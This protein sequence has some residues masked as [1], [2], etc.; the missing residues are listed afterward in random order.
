MNFIGLARVPTTAVIT[1]AANVVPLMGVVFWGW[2]LFPIIFLYWLE[3]AVIGVYNIAKLTRKNPAKSTFL[4]PIFLFHYGFFMFGHLALVYKLFAPDDLYGSLLP[5]RELLFAQ[6]LGVWPALITLGISHGTSFVKN[7]LGKHEYKDVDLEELMGAPYRRILLMQTVV[8][9]GGW[10]ITIFHAPI[11][12][13]A[14]LIVL[15]TIADVRA[16][17]QEHA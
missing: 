2:E 7:F 17:T 16:H 14:L 6:V 1:A 15:K 3:S 4:V 13:L 8:I 5:S 10:L 12:G 9:L 11:L